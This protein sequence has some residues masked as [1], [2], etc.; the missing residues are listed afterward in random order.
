VSV[1]RWEDDHEKWVQLAYLAELGLL[2]ASLVH[3]IRQPLFTIKARAQLAAAGHADP[4]DALMEIERS[5][6]HIEELLSHYGGATDVASQ[7]RVLDINLAV[8]TAIQMLDYR[9]RQIGADLQV[10]L[11]GEPLPVRVRDGAIRQVVVNL[12]QNALDAVEGQGRREVRVES[13]GGD[14][15]VEITVV[16]SGKGVAADMVD[17]MFQPFVTSKPAGKGTGLGLFVA[18]DLVEQAGGRLEIAG[19]ASAGTRATVR[20]PLVKD[21]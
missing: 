10:Q 17:R 21:S 18:R 14:E 3:E 20:L 16:D 13:H 7:L 6:E 12:V 15:W 2:T 1:W 11:A 8:N 9:A 4:R 19:G 5:V